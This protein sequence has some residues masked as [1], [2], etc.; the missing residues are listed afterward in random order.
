MYFF[1]L[2]K[3]SQLNNQMF[4]QKYRSLQMECNE[5]ARTLQRSKRAIAKGR[6]V[7]HGEEKQISLAGGKFLVVGELWV[8]ETILDIPCP[9]GVDPLSMTR[10]D[11]SYSEDRAIIT[12]I[13]ADLSNSLQEA[14]ADMDRQESFKVTVCPFSLNLLAIELCVILCAVP[15]PI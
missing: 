5:L 14:L 6:I 13:H 3:R 2:L 9:R 15:S 4:S 10:Y 11:N 8:H 12:E 1:Q 7:L